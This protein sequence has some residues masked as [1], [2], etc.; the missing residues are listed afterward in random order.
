MSNVFPGG[1]PYAVDVNRLK[2]AFPVNSLNEGLIIKHVQLEATIDAKSGTRRYYS[3]INSWLSEMK[4]SNAIFMTWEHGVGIKVLNP[5][6][7]LYHGESRVKQKSSQIQKAVK[8]FAWVSRARLDEV[9]QQRLDHQVR[10]ASA[11]AAAARSGT[12]EMAIE[13]APVKSL[14]KPQLIREAS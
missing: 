7:I 10:V 13:L 11:I 2:A 5:S 4:N 6:G 9:G 8:I 3:V 14:P 12:K 1:I